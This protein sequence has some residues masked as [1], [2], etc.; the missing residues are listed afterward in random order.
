MKKIMYTLLLMA[1]AAVAAASVAWGYRPPQPM[2]SDVNSIDSLVDAYYQTMS[3]GKGQPRDWNRL[4]TLFRH[5]A[6]LIS[7]R[8][9][10]ESGKLV[11]RMVT[12]EEYIGGSVNYFGKEG[13]YQTEMRRQ[14]DQYGQMAHVLSSYEVKH[15]RG[16]AAPFRRSLSSIQL[17]GDGERWWIQSVVWQSEEDAT[18][19]PPQYL[20]Q[21]P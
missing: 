7:L 11:S 4:R 13:F 14:V 1:L 3:G 20:K 19:L 5:D 12:V 21:T 8:R 2:P 17:V 15:E 6:R 16:D 10:K 18:A 9:D